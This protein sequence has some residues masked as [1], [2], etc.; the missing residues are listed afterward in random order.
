[1]S[2]QAWIILVVGSVFGAGLVGSLFLHEGELKLYVKTGSRMLHGEPIYRTDEVAFSYPPLFA[3]PFIPMTMLS[4]TARRLLWFTI[5]FVAVMVIAYRL[6]RRLAPLLCKARLPGCPPL[7]LF[8]LLVA[9]LSGRYVLSVF[10]YRSHDLLV[11]LCVFLAIDAGCA[12]KEGISGLLAGV[13]AA[14]KATPLLFASLFV[15]QRR[16]AAFVCLVAALLAG[17]FMPDLLWPAKDG[18]S[19]TVTWYGTFIRTAGPGQTANA[20]GAWNAWNSLNQSLAGTCYRLFTTKPAYTIEETDVCLVNLG[21]G[22]LKLVTLAG[23]LAVAAWLAWVTRRTLTS[24]RVEKG[25][26]TSRIT[27]PVPFFDTGDARAMQRLGEGAVL[28]CAMVLL[29]PMSSKT[30][31][32]VLLA[33]IAFC[34]ADFCYRRRDPLVGTA[35]VV[36]FLFGTMTVKGLLP[37]QWG[38][39]VISYGSVTWCALAMLLASGRILR[40]RAQLAYRARADEESAVRR[41]LASDRPAA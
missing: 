35:L 2:R 12:V 26:G 34:L 6:N 9:L 18:V 14:L 29:S 3:V 11:F 23:Q 21:P 5:N 28:V 30:H 1:M 17:T 20:E 16:W 40:Q 38:E 8:W 37:S 31:F 36:V 32:C 22:A 39:L 4:E 24:G 25:D 7:W 41:T 10:E 27:G 13:G 33:P 15:W 19:W